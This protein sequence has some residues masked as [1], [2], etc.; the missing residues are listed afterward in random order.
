MSYSGLAL[1][2]KR[3]TEINLVLCSRFSKKKMPDLLNH[4]DRRM[5]Q[6][7]GFAM[8]VF[9]MYSGVIL[10]Q[11]RNVYFLGWH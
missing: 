1:W 7:I 2:L 6:K 8:T 10:L 5:E 3:L 4:Q 9:S 11:R